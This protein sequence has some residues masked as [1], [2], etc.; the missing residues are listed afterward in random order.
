MND[1][2]E[3]RLS[4]LT[5]RGLRPEL[6]EKVLGAV[7]DELQAAPK[8]H[9]SPSPGQRPGEVDPVNSALSARRAN[10]SANSWPVGPTDERDDSASPGR[11]PGLGEP[12]GLRPTEPTSATVAAS[13]PTDSPWLRR[14]AT[15]VAASLLLGIG[16]NVWV[17]ETSARH[18]AELFGPPPVSK[19]AME[20][21]KDVAAVTDAQTGKWVYHLFTMPVSPAAIAAAH[22]EYYST[23]KKLID[24]LQTVSKDSYRETPQKDLE[25]DR[26]RAGRGGG[27]ST[28]CQRRFRLDYRYTA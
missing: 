17:S 4:R 12:T 11:C 25:M 20:I 27:D 6:R 1:D 26:Y 24:A 3:E 15:A 14:A 18:L 28:D 10:D 5:P 19:R 9:G 23:V 16:L 2:V 13:T 21:A 8:E 7:A 22:T